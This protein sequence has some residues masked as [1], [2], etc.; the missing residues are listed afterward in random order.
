MLGTSL[1]LFSGAG[2]LDLGLEHAG[3]STLACVEMDAGARS[4]LALNRPSWQL[5]EPS[6]VNLAAEELRPRTLG[7]RAR[8]LDLISGGP[9][10]QPFSAAAQWN[11]TSRRGMDDPRADALHGML[12]LVAEFRPRAVLLENVA[13]F[14]NGPVSA[15]P[16]LQAGFDEINIRYGTAYRLDVAVLDAADY[17]VPQHR[18]RAI[19]VARRDGKRFYFPEPTH[20]AKPVTAWDAMG[21]LPPET[22]TP[23]AGAWT[24]LLPSIPEGGNYLHMTAKGAGPELFGWRTR[25]WSFL[26]KLARARPSWTL[27]ASPGP[28]TGPFHWDNRPLTNRERMRLQSFPDSWRFSGSARAQTRLIGNATP[29]PLA[30]ALGKQLVIQLGLGAPEARRRLLR[31]PSV[32]VRNHRDDCPEPQEPM[33]LSPRFARMV[34]TKNAHPG[35]GRGPAPRERAESG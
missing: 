1:S 23:P 19:A 34:G 28:N 31:A 14:F 3:I 15:L 26:L 33:P 30:E 24:E 2:G 27:P 25:Y 7:L 32:L 22:W 4:T 21:D 16:Y 5:Y 9:P 8:Q 20:D 35:T 18:R 10:C 11:S 17:G 12:R 29:P 6:D 13:G